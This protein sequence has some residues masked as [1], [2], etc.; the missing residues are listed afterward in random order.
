MGGE[1]GIKKDGRPGQV[2]RTPGQ[3]PNLQSRPASQARP[4]TLIRVR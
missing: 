1:P 3:A 4:A 2:L